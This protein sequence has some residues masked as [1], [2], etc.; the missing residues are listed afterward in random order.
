MTKIGPEIEGIYILSSGGTL[1]SGFV[2]YIKKGEY[3]VSKFTS[4]TMVG[5]LKH[6]K[7]RIPGTLPP[8]V[9][10]CVAEVGD[11]ANERSVTY[12]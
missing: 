8:R 9:L 10:S 5:V 7:A 1:H 3:C 11:E 12:E 6:A 2:L 4:C